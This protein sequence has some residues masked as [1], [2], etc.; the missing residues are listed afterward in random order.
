MQYSPT[1]GRE[2]FADFY[3]KQLQHLNVQLTD[4]HNRPLP[5][6]GPNQTI[7]GNLHFTATFRVDIIQGLALNEAPVKTAV[8]PI[9][10]SVPARFERLLIQQK[11]GEDTYGVPMGY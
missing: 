10:H 2:F 5:A 6:F 1:S 3:Q 8:D 11:N 4:S 7:R 9:K